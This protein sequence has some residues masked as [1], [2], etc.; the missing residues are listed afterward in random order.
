MW[1]FSMRVERIGIGQ[2]N[3]DLYIGYLQIIYIVQNWLCLG[4]NIQKAPIPK[5]PL[6]TR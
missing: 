6:I 4:F 5:H 1:R 2:E 3:P